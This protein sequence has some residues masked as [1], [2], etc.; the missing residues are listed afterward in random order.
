MPSS[1]TW[2]SS[3]SGPMFSPVLVKLAAYKAC[4]SVPGVAWTEDQ[5]HDPNA[6]VGGIEVLEKEGRFHPEK[7]KAIVCAVLG[8]TLMAAQQNRQQKMSAKQADEEKIQSLW[9]LVKVLQDQL[10]N[11][12]NTTQ[13]LYTA[14]CDVLDR[15]KVL[16]AKANE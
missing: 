10:T 16:R 6:I 11:E 14:L 13:Q 15:E 5:W 4:P 12:C 7:G 3:R 2:T 8:A 1:G 9:D